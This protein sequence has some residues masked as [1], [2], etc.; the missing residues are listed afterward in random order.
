MMAKRKKPAAKSTRRKQPAATPAKSPAKSA[1]KAV[2]R[3]AAPAD[4]RAS[5]KGPVEAQEVRRQ[6]A[7]LETLIGRIEATA[8]AASKCGID[9]V[10]MDGRGQLDRGVELVSKFALSYA[11]WLAREQATREFS[12]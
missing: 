11:S 12:P 10:E 3:G 7:S 6:L 4:G 8:A 2:S 9:P 1:A 5:R